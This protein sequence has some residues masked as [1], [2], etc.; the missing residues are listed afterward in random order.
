[1]AEFFLELFSEEVPASLQKNA[2]QN[3]LE[4]FKRLFDEKN[5]SFKKSL[6]Y[7]IPNRLVILF[8]DLQKEFIEQKEE[9]ILY[10]SYVK[11][12]KKTQ[13]LLENEEYIKAME[14][15]SEIALELENFFEK[16]KV[17]IDREDIRNNRLKLLSMIRSSF[18]NFA[19]FSLI[20][21]ENEGK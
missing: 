17:N 6:S 20:E 2:R 12:S 7:S 15:F 11:Y 13:L 4:S 18:L 5:L 3:V 14:I 10:K 16:V 8:E 9:I 19:D 1:M 21:A